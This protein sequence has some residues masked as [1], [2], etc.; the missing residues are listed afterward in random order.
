VNLFELF[1]NKGPAGHG[2]SSGIGGG[3]GHRDSGLELPQACERLAIQSRGRRQARAG[4][5]LN[6]R[7]QV[8]AGFLG[9]ERLL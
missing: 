1:E 3:F 5:R 6:R 9:H 2:F 4:W 7:V 8:G